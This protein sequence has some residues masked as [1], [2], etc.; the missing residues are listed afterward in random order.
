MAPATLSSSNCL[1]PINI[2][3]TDPTIRE[4]NILCTYQYE[5][6]DSSCIVSTDTTTDPSGNYLEIK[7]DLKN[8][9]TSS[10]VIFNGENYNVSLIKVYQPS[11]HTYD[12]INAPIELLIFHDGPSDSNGNTKKLVVSIP[13]QSGSASTDYT[14]SKT[15]S[16]VLESIINEYS[17][18]SSSSS[19]QN[20][21]IKNFNLNNFI[22]NAQYYY[23]MGTDLPTMGVCPKTSITNYVLFDLSKGGQYISSDAVTKLQ[24]LIGPT[25]GAFPIITTNTLYKSSKYPNSNSAA[26]MSGEIYIDCNP[27]G[28][29]GDELYKSTDNSAGE[30]SGI[31]NLMDSLKS[32]GLVQFL[33]S[34]I[35]SIVLIIVIQKAFFTKKI[36]SAASAASAAA[37]AG[38]GK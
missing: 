3:S 19:S 31:N 22:P 35:L 30:I 12:T 33:V 11:L 15:G 25:S 18:L 9:G 7:Y 24:K 26:D 13:Y 37:S 21:N 29:E 6:N 28:S 32:S 4:C 5:Y 27:T 34:I 16:Q 1:A 23:Y 14:S 17:K 20:L 10:Q 8:S 2:S 36:P 38:T